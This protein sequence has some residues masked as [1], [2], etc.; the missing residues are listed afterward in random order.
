LETLPADYVEF[1]PSG[2]IKMVRAAPYIVENVSEPTS[3]E[4]PK[5][6]VLGMWA[7][8]RAQRTG[9]RVCIINAGKSQS[10]A[11]QWLPGTDNYN[12]MVTRARMALYTPGSYCAGIIGFAGLND[13]LDVA[14]AANWDT[15][16]AA[17]VAGLR[18]E[19]GDVPAY[20]VRYPA[21]VPPAPPFPSHAAVRAA[22]AAATFLDGTADAPEGPWVDGVH[23]DT[24]A[25]LGA[26]VALDAV[27][28]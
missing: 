28:P 5:C 3:L 1:W 19:F 23:L 7:W 8:K 9:R 11:V 12:G 22:I 25:N 13:A 26:A 27:V 6:G 18:A 20:W 17:M 16:T 2:R 24:P 21:T 14:G 4:L 10:R 15:N